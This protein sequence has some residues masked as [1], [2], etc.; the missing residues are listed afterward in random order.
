MK[1]QDKIYPV[2]ILISAL[3][4]S[5][6]AAFYS[7]TGIGQVF[8]GSAK[9]VMV[10]AGA[11]EIGKLIV[12]GALHHY[13]NDISKWFRNYLAGAV[14]VLIFITSMGIFGFLSNAYKVT[15]SE[16]EIQK[17]EISIIE[18]KQDRFEE[19]KL[20]LVNEKTTITSNVADLTRS[21][22]KGNIVEYIDKETGEKITTT[23]SSARRAIQ[24]ELK[25]AKEES[26]IISSK[27]DVLNDTITALDIEMIT[28]ESN[29]EASSDLGPLIYV[30]ELTGWS[31]DKTVSGFI[32]VLIFIFDPLAV[33]MVIFFSM[34]LDKLNRKST[35]PPA[36]IP[37]PT[38]IPT[39]SPSPPSSSA[40]PVEALTEPY[41]EEVDFTPSGIGSYFDP[42]KPEQNPNWIQPLQEL[43]ESAIRSMTQWQ[44]DDYNK[45]RK[46]IND[47]NSNL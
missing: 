36:P 6:S 39:P 31:M 8:A 5:A 27:I 41:F 7:V 22:G 14:I 32:L 29:S 18:A 45:R 43:N 20:E 28:I 21:L 4:I 15:S 10:M 25:D 30:S 26:K 12:A 2:L 34:S 23:S 9:Q 11:L 1:L 19:L 44:I 37:S 46:A 38:P 40:D 47:H 35:I 17:K 3:S 13:W 33:S 42:I 16:L 24:Q